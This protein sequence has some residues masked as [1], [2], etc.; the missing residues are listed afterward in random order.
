M[1]GENVHEIINR[2][3]I[4]RKGTMWGDDSFDYEE[5]IDIIIALFLSLYMKEK[6]V[7][8]WM[9]KKDIEVKKV[10]LKVQKYT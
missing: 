10:H 7:R 1:H 4:K 3:I 8:T 2:Q 9:T 6:Y 5:N